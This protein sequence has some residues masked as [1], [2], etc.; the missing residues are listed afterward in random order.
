M[1]DKPDLI[2][3]DINSFPSP[4]FYIYLFIF[5]NRHWIYG[6]YTG[7]H[8]IG[9][10]RIY[11][12]FPPS[13]FTFLDFFFTSYIIIFRLLTVGCGFKTRIWNFFSFELICIKSLINRAETVTDAVFVLFVIYSFLLEH[14]EWEII[15][16]IFSLVFFL[17]KGC[18][19]ERNFIEHWVTYVVWFDY[20]FLL[21]IYSVFKDSVNTCY[22]F[23]KIILLIKVISLILL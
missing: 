11:S 8:R 2:K 6:S 21:F 9:F 19:L 7:R 16:K 17:K 3:Y 20:L 15:R 23:D 14:I 1:S 4:R 5:F 22:D 13:Y 18:L 12:A 10:V